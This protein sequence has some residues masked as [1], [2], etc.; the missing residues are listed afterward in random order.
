[1][2]R[3]QKALASVM[4]VMMLVSALP[5][6]VLAEEAKPETVPAAPA[7]EITD[8]AND[9]V[10]EEA[11]AP[12]ETPVPEAVIDEVTYNLLCSE[13][14]VGSDEAQEGGAY[15]LFDE[16]GNY[17]IPLED[18]AFFPYEVQFAYEG[19][20]WT[21]WF[22]DPEDTVTVGGH[23][24]SVHS[25]ST[26]PTTLQQAGFWIGDDYVP[27]FPEEKT[28]TPVSLMSL[29]PLKEHNLYVD[30]LNILHPELK[31]VKASVLLNAINAGTTSNIPDNQVFVWAKMETYGQT[32]NLE[33][34]PID[35][36]S[37]ATMDL[38]PDSRWAD[39]SKLSLIVGTGAADQLNPDN[40]R[41][42]VSLQI[43]SASESLFTASAATTEPSRQALT[44]KKVY[45][46]WDDYRDEAP[47]TRYDITVQD[48]NWE[49]GTQKA[50]SLQLDNSKFADAAADLT[51]QFFRGF[52]TSVE[53]I[54]A[55]KAEDITA[56]IWDTD[57]T[58]EGQGLV[59]KFYYNDPTSQLTVVMKRGDVV[60]AVEPMEI[61]VNPARV[62]YS[63]DKI[64]SGS[65][66]V[67][68]G[69]GR[70]N[71]DHGF[72]TMTVKISRNYSVTGTYQLFMSFYDNASESHDLSSIVWA[73]AGRYNTVEALK[74][75]PNI[76][77]E[78]FTSSRQDGSG[79]TVDFSKPVEFTILDQYEN[80]QQFRIVLEQRAEDNTDSLPSAPQPAEQD[81]YF[82]MNGA[83]VKTVA[84]EG[85]DPA[86]QN[87]NAYVMNPWDDSYYFNGYQT[88]FLLNED[89]TA[90]SSET[91][92]PSFYT[93]NKVTMYAGVD[94]TSGTKQVSR[95]TEL[96]FQNGEPIQ[97]S[98]AAES[99]GHLKNY[100]VTFVTQKADGPSLFVNAAND[101]DRVDEATK[102]PVREVYLT[103]EFENH[104]DVFF[105][106][107]GDAPMTGISVTLE[108]AQNVAL[109]EYWTIREDGTRQLPA[110]KSVSTQDTDGKYTQYGGLK[111]SAK[112]RLVP[113][114]DEKGQ[115][116]AGDISGVLVISYLGAE[117]KP[118]ETRIKLTGTA[119]V[120]KITTEKIRD[121]VKF[122]PY[123]SV[124]QTNS[125]GASDAI[126]F[127]VES[128]RLPTGV[129]LFPNGKLYGMP[130][131]A[132][133]FT[134]TVKAVYQN[135]Q[136]NAMTKKFT[137]LIAENTDANVDAATDPG[138]T[139]LDRVPAQIEF[140][141]ADYPEFK[142][143][144]FRSEGTYN[145]FMKFFLDGRELTEGKD[146]DSE[147][148][149]TKITIHA[150]TFQGLNNGTHT[151]AAE[152]RTNKSDT[153]TVKRAAQNF[154]ISGLPTH[155]GGNGGGTSKPAVRPQKPQQPVKPQQ[156]IVGGYQDVHANDWFAADIQWAK[157]QQLMIGVTTTQFKPYNLISPATVVTVLSRMDQVDLSKYAGMQDDDIPAGQWYTNAALWAKEAGLLPEGKFSAQPP[158][159]R[160]QFA[161]IL[162]KYLQHNGV[163]CTLPEVLVT[164]ADADLMTA[165][166]NEAFQVLYQ[167]GIFKGVG[168]YCMDAEGPT[169]RAQL[170]VLLHRLSVFA[171]EHKN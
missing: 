106:N 132:G 68:T 71:W 164:F 40:T 19:D 90:V 28:F 84:E 171:E 15:V 20:T 165:E 27:A 156:P 39:E 77:T 4:A 152:F 82:H 8:V 143:E 22:M 33:Y 49:Y 120:P 118:V 124:I 155:S 134:F 7:T 123:N 158:I 31:N 14:T 93:G 135:N 73:A 101:P 126:H 109:D 140:G 87:L 44:V 53:A 32:T 5:A 162:H 37:G 138:Y 91:I 29:Q 26:D 75:Q 104:H 145:Q 6:T 59:G 97:Y 122:V 35:P 52:F 119:G 85:T 154:T 115:P 127:S 86:V 65:A 151:I 58:Q 36:N 89:Q 94:H 1:M 16:N 54:E 10:S 96:P 11:P 60:V 102:L 3:F 148:G 24:F 67:S 51:F 61:N 137:V 112:I 168:G 47:L 30:L 62:S 13:I 34:T 108:N 170:A 125:M 25:E 41:Y 150:Q 103:P 45:S 157:E 43:H 57:P 88:V 63:V 131:E 17:T 110:F 159:A 147:E 42:T 70:D 141:S 113:A 46:F 64:E 92:I 56:Q 79:Y 146:F 111:N 78:L 149:S 129:E 69:G 21:E 99:V 166:E 74:K 72:K 50:V 153:N 142:N 117:N 12:E 48:P 167:F 9:E 107:I 163:D 98:A 161:V 95:E 76:K 105:A 55:A 23:E 100:W 121:G 169:T 139:L 66:K 128:G 18:N 133:S 2:K 83:S 130:T 144:V 160:A 116:L 136:D 114:V 38:R 81:T 80:L